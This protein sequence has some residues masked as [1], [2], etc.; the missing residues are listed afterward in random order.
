MQIFKYLTCTFCLFF[1]F[2]NVS[3][4]ASGAS[5]TSLSPAGLW[6]NI[7][8]AT[9]KPRS[10]IRI[11]DNNGEFSAVVEKGLLE[12]D[13]GEK[14]C[15]KCTD[16]RKDQKVIGMTIVKGIHKKGIIYEGGNILDP[17]NGKV[18]KCKM[19]LI[20]DGNKLE[21]RGFIGMSLF[22]RSQIWLREE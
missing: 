9:G 16:E 22:G 6:K 5:H 17:D 4:F 21:V 12:T 15:D 2:C 13:T 14:I 7:D 20:E 8:D 18:Y 11:I 10:L 3:A 19:K 1:L